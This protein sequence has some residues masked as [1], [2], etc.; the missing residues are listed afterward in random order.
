MILKDVQRELATNMKHWQ[1]I[2]NLAIASTGRIIMKTDNPII[3]LIM[4]IIQRD[5][6]MHYLVQEWIA[7]SLSVKPVSL[8]YDDLQEV[9][10]MIG[11]HVRLEHQM[12]DSVK[13]ALA[14]VKGKKMVVH[15]YLLNY[16]HD[17]EAKH[18]GL[19][20]QLDVIKKDMLS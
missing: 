15:E 8:S 18:D 2:E 12:M 17:D 6:Q 7:D 14:L 10:E 13:E 16:L 11:K 4:E 9:W 19:L 1:N 5:S 20:K 3:R